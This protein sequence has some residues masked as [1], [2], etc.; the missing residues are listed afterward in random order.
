MFRKLFFRYP[1]IAFLF[2]VLPISVFSQQMNDWENP[3]F[4]EL[5]KEKPHATSMLFD[6][7]Q[8]VI[9]DDYTA[10]PYYQS[11]NGSWKFSYVPRHTER[12]L[13]FFKPALDTK[14]WSE[15]KVPS[16]WEV[17]GFGIPIYTNIV[18]P[19][20]KNPPLIG[21][22]N[23]V[24]TYRKEFE[25]PATWDGRQVFLHFGSISGCAFVYVNGQKVGMSKV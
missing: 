3:A 9:A 25:V 4:V 18:Y 20:P 23:P 12:S 5:N 13:D 22:D 8:K 15:I 1:G 24:G 16:N 14:S 17:E 21:G 7:K 11:L 19:F 2:V 10:S 6:T